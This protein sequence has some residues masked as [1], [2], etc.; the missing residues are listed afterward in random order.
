MSTR[1]LLAL[2]FIMV[3]VYTV[4]GEISNNTS[5]I[6]GN[7]SS[8]NND[9][10]NDSYNRTDKVIIEDNTKDT[11]S[12]ITIKIYRQPKKA[13]GFE[14]ITI[15]PIIMIIYILKTKRDIRKSSLV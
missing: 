9:S 15:I 13:S 6:Y 4:N 3:F 2:V 14:A 5:H 8:L 11:K 12:K 10:Y 1:I 7:N